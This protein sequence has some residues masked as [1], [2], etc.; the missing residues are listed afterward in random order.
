VDAVEASE[1]AGETSGQFSFQFEER[2]D[3]VRAHSGGGS[4]GRRHAPVPGGAPAFQRVFT[5]LGLTGRPP[6]FVIEF[7]PYAGLAHSIRKR[8][9]TIFASLSD[10]LHD[11]PVNIIE[12]IAGILLARLYR[13]RTPRKFLRDY[14][15]Y[16]HEPHVRQRVMTM[17]RG[18][19]RRI[20]HHP[21]GKFHNLAEI[22]EKLNGQYFGGSVTL[23]RLGWSK[24][25]WRSML[26]CYDAALDQ[27][28]ISK[29]LDRK[30][31]PRFVVEYIVYHEMLHIKHPQKSVN[32]R[33]ESHSA[34]FRAEEKL[35]SHYK[36]AIR[37]LRG[38]S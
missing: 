28:V 18:R 12:A 1:V 31:V 2:D 10:L 38:L 6:E 15:E 30:K 3:G 35:F 25:R 4:G 22:F 21:Q 14:R 32:C 13:Q 7:R 37:A 9:G 27:I 36:Q 24:K 5:R 11:A 33:L 17:R 20:A 34:K 8:E 16:A 23:P 19:G 29:D 26:G